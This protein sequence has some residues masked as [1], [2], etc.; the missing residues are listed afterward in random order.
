[1][2]LCILCSLTPYYLGYQF[3]RFDLWKEDWKTS[4]YFHIFNT[5]MIKHSSKHYNLSIHKWYGCVFFSYVISDMSSLNLYGYNSK[6]LIKLIKLLAICSIYR[7]LLKAQKRPW[8]L[9]VLVGTFKPPIT[10]YCHKYV[11]IFIPNVSSCHSKC[12]S[13]GSISL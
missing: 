10:P 2:R 5:L 12:F 8:A 9:R 11:H 6:K 13:L 7:K 1:L 3:F 4:N